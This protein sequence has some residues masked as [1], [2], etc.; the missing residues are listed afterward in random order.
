MLQRIVS[1][2]DE[3]NNLCYTSELTPTEK[4]LIGSLIKKGLVYDGFD[5]EYLKEIDSSYDRNN[6]FPTEEA[7]SLISR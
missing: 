1:E 2:Y 5:D 6:F 3:N 4:G 7:L